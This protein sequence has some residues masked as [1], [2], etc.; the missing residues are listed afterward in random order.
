MRVLDA[1]Y[2]L[3]AFSLLVGGV[4]IVLGQKLVW[5]KR[6]LN[7][8]QQ[9]FVASQKGF[10]QLKSECDRQR[11]QLEWMRI[12]LS[13]SGGSTPY[14][15]LL[16]RW[17]DGQPGLLA[18]IVYG[19]GQ[20]E[21]LKSQFQL[22]EIQK[23]IPDR[24]QMV[25]F[26]RSIRPE[27]FDN[28]PE[29]VTS[30][31][32]FRCSGEF[33]KSELF[34]LTDLPKCFSEQSDSSTLVELFSYVDCQPQSL[35]P[36]DFD[37]APN[38][39]TVL[40]K[41][42]LEIRSLLDNEFQSPGEMMEGFLRKLSE[43][44]GYA[45]ASLYLNHDDS[46][47]KQVYRRF[48]SGGTLCDMN[49]TG[50]Q[51]WF[52]AEGSFV[53]KFANCLAAPLLLT[54]ET[55]QMQ[56]DYVPFRCGMLI[57]VDCGQVRLGVLMLTHHEP[58]QPDYEETQFIDWASSFLMQSLRRELKRAE[59]EEQARRDPLT[60]V[61]NRRTFDQEL[62]RH[63][64]FANQTESDLSLIMIDVDHFKS[65]NDRFGHQVG[66]QVL[67]KVGEVLKELSETIRV[68]DQA[69]AARY[70]GEEFAVL[71]PN[72]GLHDAMK[73]AERLRVAVSRIAIEL[74]QQTLS[75]TASLGVSS[76]VAGLCTSTS[77]VQSADAALYEAKRN[78]RNQVRVVNE[79][80]QS[81]APRNGKEKVQL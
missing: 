8:W 30:L 28:L 2:M 20:I 43:I 57:P 31:F 13:P 58:S 51:D 55:I 1:I 34:V 15:K 45:W 61:A 59:V 5:L 36:N 39:E 67:Q 66:D 64:S 63:V 24:E 44:S 56:T 23:H 9:D 38:I 72:A 7:R 77:L 10:V 70:G 18:W 69:L 4:G 71:L 37:R 50:L 48:A 46:P 19:N 21:A 17:W 47:D 53:E 76:L 54:S 35:P 65:V 27:F 26:R 6:D 29:W 12:T 25:T 60:R 22:P 32:V 40:A 41:E 42:M 62:Q 16:E 11:F 74:P 73:I 14:F 33:G 81:H 49:E 75:V 80:E 52:R 68:G 79:S 3:G 78:G